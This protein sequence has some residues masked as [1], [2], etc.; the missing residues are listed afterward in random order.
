MMASLLGDFLREAQT[1]TPNALDVDG[2]EEDSQRLFREKTYSRLESFSELTRFDLDRENCLNG[3]AL[4]SVG[5]IADVCADRVCSDLSSPALIHGDL[6]FSNILFDSRAK[7]I[8]LIDPRGINASG[9]F[10]LYGDQRYDLAKLLHSSFGYYDF[11]IAGA[12]TL[13]VI[14]DH[15]FKFNIHVD[16]R[17]AISSKAFSDVLFHKVGQ[18]VSLHMVV[19]LFL[20][21]LPLHQ[22][23]PDRQKAMLA[24]A[25]RI[26]AAIDT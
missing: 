23:R 18:E 9:K 17:T 26:F 8:K 25:L 3:V 7:S 6:C 14:G 5:A 2:I 16:S 11:V 15:N 20:A 22:D 24:N 12:Y 10:M 1:I 19:L 13:D 4:P 21:M